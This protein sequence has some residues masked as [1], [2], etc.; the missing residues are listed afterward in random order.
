MNSAMLTGRHAGLDPASIIARLRDKR[1]LML[2]IASDGCRIKSGMT[3]LAVG[4][5]AFTAA[6]TQPQVIDSTGAAAKNWCKGASNC[7]VNDAPQ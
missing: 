6:C 7:T 1:T 5:M 4:V 3:A 2:A